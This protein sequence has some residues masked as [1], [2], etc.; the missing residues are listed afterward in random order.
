[1]LSVT[2]IVLM[3]I[4]AVCGLYS[5]AKIDMQIDES[6]T[7]DQS[8]LSVSHISVCVCVCVCARARACMRACL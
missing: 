2:C 4:D 1:M 5:P 3:Y 6:S 7:C 8:S